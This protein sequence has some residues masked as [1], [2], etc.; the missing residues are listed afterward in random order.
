LREN[1]KEVNRDNLI[2]GGRKL[3]SDGG[4]GILAELL[5]KANE[6]ENNF[7]I[8]SVRT[9]DEAK[10]LKE[11]KSFKL[12]EVRASREVR[13]ERMKARGRKGDPTDYETFVQ[14]EEAE[15]KASDSSGQALDA[16][17]KEADIVIDNESDLN[18]LFLEIDKLLED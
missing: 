3:R 9:P 10:A 16:T 11:K 15:L 1:G 2:E 5:L 17:A 13:W 18:A 6:N 14:Q 4:P 7:A 8:D 12:I